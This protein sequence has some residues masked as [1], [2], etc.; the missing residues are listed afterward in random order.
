[1]DSTKIIQTEQSILSNEKL[2]HE[3]TK[4]YLAMKKMKVY[5]LVSIPV[6]IIIGFFC[7]NYQVQGSTSGYAG[8]YYSENPYE[9]L[10]AILLLFGLPI[11]VILTVLGYVKSKKLASPVKETTDEIMKLKNE[12]IV[13]KNS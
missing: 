13:L 12:L 11:A 7:V 1:M 5:A 6:L 9:G 3:Q 10:G 8:I 4:K 2:L